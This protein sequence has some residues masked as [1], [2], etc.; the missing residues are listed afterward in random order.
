MN[1][2]KELSLTVKCEVYTGWGNWSYQKDSAGWVVR[3]VSQ[4]GCLFLW[5]QVSQS[6]RQTA[7]QPVLR[8]VSH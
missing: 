5:Q 2:S 1:N 7:S 8:S 3:S 6:L 4:S